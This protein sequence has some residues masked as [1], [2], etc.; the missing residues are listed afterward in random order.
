MEQIVNERVF[1]PLSDHAEKW[2]KC[3]F[4]LAYSSANFAR[5]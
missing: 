4:L 1:V 3:G 2:M 5:Y